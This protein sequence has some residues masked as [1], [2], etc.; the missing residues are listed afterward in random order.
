LARVSLGIPARDRSSF[1]DEPTYEELT[2][3]LAASQ[4]AIEERDARIF[5]LESELQSLHDRIGRLESEL[6]RNSENSS[7]PPS[8]D[9]IATRQ[10]RAE[11]RA[12]ARAARSSERSQGKQ[13]GSPGAHLARRIASTTFRYAPA[14]CGRCGEDLGAGEVTGEIVRQVLDIPDIVLVAT[15]HV[16]E[17]R[18]CHCGHE[19]TGAFPDEARAPV[20]WGPGVRAFAVYLMDRQH[21]P[22]ERTAELLSEILGADV[23]TGWLCQVQQEA[24]GR[25]AAFVETVTEQL[26]DSPV[27]HAD[28]TGTRVKTHKRWVHTVATEMLTLLGVH[29]KRGL[30]AFGAMGVLPGFGGVVV[31]DGWGPYDALAGIMHAQ[32]HVHLVRHLRAVGETPEFSIWTAQLRRVLRDATSASEAAAVAGLG[33]IP[34]REANRIVERYH[35]A[36]DVA[37]ALLPNGPPP[38]R[39]HRDGWSNEQRAAWNL[40]TRMRT[41]APAVLRLLHDTAVP[42]DNNLAERALRMVKV[43]DKVSGSF[44]SDNG[45]R[46]FVTI[47]SYLQTAALQGQN[48][49]AVLHQL[50]AEG[51]WLPEARAG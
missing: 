41:Q 47:R 16:A 10:S 20:C 32:C 28:E 11:R 34:R 13:P 23:S 38:R 33:K 48:R 12:Q 7:K 36:L 6:S 37:F 43:H 27:V 51:P 22:L 9:P 45:A 15:D 49:L 39:R 50:F 18:R 30:E 2:E 31:H 24:A 17:R 25:L 44:R 8:S 21:I 5:E 42:A 35:E 4:L 14:A 3:Q 40:A 1:D 19:T 46:A 26:R 29:E